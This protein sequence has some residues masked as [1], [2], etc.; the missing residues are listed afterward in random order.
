MKITAT[1]VKKILKDEYG[2]KNID[3]VCEEFYNTQLIKH[4]ITIIDAKLKYHKGISIK[5]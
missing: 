4:V 2:Y 3:C 5:K 1:N